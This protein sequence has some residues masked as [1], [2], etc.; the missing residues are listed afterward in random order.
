ME[1]C[2]F[3]EKEWMDNSLAWAAQCG[4]DRVVRIL[5]S[6]DDIEADKPDKYGRTPLL[7]AARNGNEEMVRMLLGRND[8]NPNKPDLDGRTSLSLAARNGYLD[9]TTS[10]P[11]ILI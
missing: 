6:E 2:C 1:D 3:S 10:T 8:V 11:M 7:L 9:G 4:H 5:L